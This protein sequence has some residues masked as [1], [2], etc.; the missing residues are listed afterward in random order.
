MAAIKSLCVKNY[1]IRCRQYPSSMLDY[2]YTINII[3]SHIENT[4]GRP[5]K[6]TPYNYYYNYST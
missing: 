3:H 5:T 2:T 6:L 1:Y 4:S